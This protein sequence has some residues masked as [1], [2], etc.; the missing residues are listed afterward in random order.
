MRLLALLTPC[1]VLALL[2]A[3]QRLEAW[4][5][6]ASG[7]HGHRRPPDTRHRSAPAR[8]RLEGAHHG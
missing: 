3:L 7:P 1:V 8:R 5:K 6:D 4:M 2:W